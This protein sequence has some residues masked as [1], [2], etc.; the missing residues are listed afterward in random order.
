MGVLLCI[1]TVTCC[2]IFGN[3]C[4]HLSNMTGTEPCLPSPLHPPLIHCPADTAVQASPIFQAALEQWFLNSFPPLHNVHLRLCC[5]CLIHSYTH[6]KHPLPKIKGLDVCWILNGILFL[7]FAG[8]WHIARSA[9]ACHWPVVSTHPHT[10][11]N[12]TLPRWGVC[13]SETDR[14]R[15]QLVSSRHSLLLFLLIQVCVCFPGANLTSNLDRIKIVFTPMRCRRVCDGGRC[16]NGCEKGD[17][18]TVYSETSHQQQPKN[19]GFRLCECQLWTHGL[20]L[21]LC[22]SCLLDILSFFSFSFLSLLPSLLLT[23]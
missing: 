22:P 8:E 21:T 10:L 6:P 14:G 20:S 2:D 12:L 23:F 18:T 13:H 3:L 19:Q 5:L 15:M 7:S 11:I 17:I 1:C 9:P 4:C 16:Y